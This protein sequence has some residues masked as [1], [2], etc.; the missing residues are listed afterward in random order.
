MV[1]SASLDLNA[2]SGVLTNTWI[3]SNDQAE[4]AVHID[5][6]APPVTIQGLGFHSAVFVNTSNSAARH[7]IDNCAFNQS[8]A[9]VNAD[10]HRLAGGGLHVH[11]GSIDIRSSSFSGM[12]AL[13]GGAFA[14]TLLGGAFA[15]GC[16]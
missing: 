16:P 1:I 2:P 5:G 10:T 12:V 8:E 3:Q 11:A 13:D 4:P 14:M 15:K 7:S 6:G 9:T